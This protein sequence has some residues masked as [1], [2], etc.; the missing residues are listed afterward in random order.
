MY[1]L[2]VGRFC[3]PKL[4]GPK[5]PCPLNTLL[6]YGSTHFVNRIV[7]F[8]GSNW[9]HAHNGWFQ[10][11]KS[12]ESSGKRQQ[13]SPRFSAIFNLQV[14]GDVARSDLQFCSLCS[15]CEPKSEVWMVW[16]ALRSHHIFLTV[17][18]RFFKGNLLLLNKS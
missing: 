12:A 9:I 8:C 15:F 17:S 7:N 14:L 3:W 13:S 11:E 6:A 16:M 10:S 18:P 2:L 4:S 5:T 1:C